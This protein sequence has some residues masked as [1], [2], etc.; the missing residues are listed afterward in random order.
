MNLPLRIDGDNVLAMF[1]GTMAN[2][3]DFK[4]IRQ[5]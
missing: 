5:K 4:T 3:Q 2:S 1:M